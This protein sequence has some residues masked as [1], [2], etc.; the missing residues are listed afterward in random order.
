METSTSGYYFGIE[1]SSPPGPFSGIA[2]GMS[3]YLGRR[4]VQEIVVMESRLDRGGD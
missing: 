3:L 2:L 4:G 1:G